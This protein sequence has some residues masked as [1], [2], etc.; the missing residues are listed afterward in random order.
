[1]I[2]TT[3]PIDAVD[4]PAASR[5]RRPRSIASAAAIAWATEKQT[6]VLTLIPAAV[7]SSIAAIPAA[8]AGN[9]TMMFGASPWKWRPWASIRSAER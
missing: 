4:S 1:M 6:V 9:L 5:R 8:V 7:A 3:G 2:V